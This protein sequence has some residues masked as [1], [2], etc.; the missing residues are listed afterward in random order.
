MSQSD[1]LLQTALECG[2]DDLLKYPVLMDYCFAWLSQDTLT[3]RRY[4]PQA[5]QDAKTW[6][7][8]T[9]IHVLMD[10][11]VRDSPKFP[12][13]VIGLNDSA[14]EQSTLGD[15][16]YF[17]YEDAPAAT[18]L[19]IVDSNRNSYN[20]TTG[21]M[22][23][24]NPNDIPV[25]TFMLVVD[26]ETKL[27]YPIIDI[28]T[29]SS[30]SITTGLSSPFKFVAVVPANNYLSVSLESS[31]FRESYSV[32]CCDNTKAQ[33]L[34]Y[35][36]SVTKFCLLRYREAYIENR[37]FE[38]TR[39]SSG[40]MSQDPVFGTEKVFN[41]SLQISGMSQRRSRLKSKG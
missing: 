25:T 30:F 38:Q 22:T 11:T 40:R 9:K 6:F 18:V 16:N 2:F 34:M 8:N 20:A 36:Y 26:L 17:P 13:V 5:L 15:V 28:E 21:K 33:N 27:S 39:I 35:L 31:R 14:E 3:A 41:R 23:I 4:G 19:S 10:Y 37:G 7:L 32:L 29:N 12:C 24:T 1:I